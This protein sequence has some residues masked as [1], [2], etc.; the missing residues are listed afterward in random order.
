MIICAERQI[1]LAAIYFMEIIDDFEVVASSQITFETFLKVYNLRKYIIRKLG[2]F[3][4]ASM[5]IMG[6]VCNL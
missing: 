6:I 1:E 5:C 2:M 4:V 3:V